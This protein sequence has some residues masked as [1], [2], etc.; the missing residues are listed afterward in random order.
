MT[1]ALLISMVL[2][3]SGSQTGVAREA[4]TPG[5]GRLK[6]DAINETR[7]KGLDEVTRAAEEATE[8]YAAALQ[9][10]VDAA[11]ASGDK[12]GAAAAGQA[13]EAIQGGT[14]PTGTES[15]AAVAALAKS[16]LKEKQRLDSTQP[17]RTKAVW[18]KHLKD[19]NEL[20]AEKARL[21][22]ASE[23]RAMA[24]EL[25]NDRK[26]L[27]ELATAVSPTPSG[28]DANAAAAAGG[29]GPA[30]AAKPWD[31]EWQIRYGNNQART[32]QITMKSPTVLQ[33]QAT[34][35]TWATDASYT[36]NY[37]PSKGCFMTWNAQG[38][39]ME[40]RMESYKLN[41]ETLEVG[42]WSA[43]QSIDKPETT[44]VGHRTKE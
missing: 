37:L 32:L 12:A 42:H 1:R 35:G 28:D 26:M 31:G 23:E 25:A 15:D 11:K 18:E 41:G 8:R 40:Q 43:A 3:F 24:A 13:L 19:L 7:D 5:A 30:K 36:A 34:G 22:D 17:G 14:A 4:A 21:G 20:A 9:A 44:G 2:I 39:G 6:L 33:I 27:A 10:R 38:A 16:Y 29:K